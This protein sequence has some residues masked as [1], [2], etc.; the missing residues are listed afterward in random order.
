MKIFFI[1]N[2]LLIANIG[3]AWLANAAIPP[4]CFQQQLPTRNSADTVQPLSPTLL[5]GKGLLQHDFLYTGEWDYRK[6]VQTIF[7][8]RNGKMV[9]S[10]PVPFKDSM[11]NMVELGDATMRSNGNI[12]F[13]T[14]I[15]ACEITPGKK[16]IWSYD[17]PKGTEIHVVQPLGIDRVFFVINGVPAIAKIV[18]VETGKT[19]KEFYLPTGKPGAHLQ[20]RRVRLLQSGHILAAHLDDDKVAEYDST[21]KVTWFYAVLKPWSASRLKNG[22]TLIT[23]SE[24][25]VREVNANGEVVW[26][27]DSIA[28]IPLYQ[29]Q[30]AERLDNGNT[31]LCNWCPKAIKNS[32][33]WPGTV[34]LLE[35]SPGKKLV[36]AL[37]EWKNPD[38]GPSSSI[39]ILDKKSLRKIKAYH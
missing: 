13:C 20:F 4:A 6:P 31:V 3:I 8:V 39:Q 11:A 1:K 12:V 9:W 37:S 26:E 23:S 25:H 15:G 28:G 22:N 24:H 16:I 14:R 30:A 34:Q 17:A 32:N 36:W 35:V 5:P 7:L 2:I 19:E 21:G 10:Y 27:L 38:L 18:N 29:I 33:D